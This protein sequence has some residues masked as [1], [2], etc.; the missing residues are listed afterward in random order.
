MERGSLI[1]K[2]LGFNEESVLT[3]TGVLCVR[4]GKHTG[5]SPKGKYIVRD[6]ESEQTVDW[7][8]NQAM[9]QEEWNSLMG[10]VRT[11][12]EAHSE[13][14]REFFNIIRTAGKATRWVNR[15]RKTFGFICENPT[16]ALFIKNMFGECDQLS[17]DEVEA[18]VYCLPGLAKEPKVVLNLKEKKIIIAGTKYLGEIKKSVFTYM[19]YV[20]TDSNVLPMHCSV[21]T[22]ENFQNPAIFFGL[23]GTGKT[24]LSASPDRVLLGDDEHGWTKGV[25]FNIESGCYAKTVNLSL[26][27]EPEIFKACQK[28]GTILENVRVKKGSPDFSDISLTANGRASYP[29]N[30]IEN[31]VP[32]GFVTSNPKNVIMLTCDATGVLPPVSKLTLDQAKKMFLVGYTSKVAGTEVGV[33]EPEL[34]FSPCFGGPFLPRKPSVYAD[35][36]QVLIKKTNANCWLVNTGWAGG[37]PGVGNRIELSVTRKIIDAIVNENLASSEWLYHEQTGLTI[38][39][40]VPGT[41]FST[42]PEHNWSSLNDYNESANYLMDKIESKIREIL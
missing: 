13:Y 17:D 29:I 5:R 42:R 2:S 21:N 16:Q 20:L 10:S 27:S 40:R 30:F 6:S 14:G 41:G 38:P 35:M 7:S 4:S 23:S 26:E 31:H 15:T 32:E 37:P 12:I 9:S 33:V 8:S 18:E 28:F 1:K 25:V 36:L 34:V 3:D 22:D 11:Y 39:D 19:N 24:T